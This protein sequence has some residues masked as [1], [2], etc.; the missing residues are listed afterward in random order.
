MTEIPL[1]CDPDKL[2]STD[3]LLPAIV[4]ALDAAKFMKRYYVRFRLVKPDGVWLLW[5][6]GIDDID[7]YTVQLTCQSVGT[8]V[9]EAARDLI[10]NYRA[11]HK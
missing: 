10:D 2:P 5:H 8:P 6:G 9:A 4:A 11:Y 1:S 7:N 3:D